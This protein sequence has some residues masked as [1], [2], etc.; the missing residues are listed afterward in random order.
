M[1]LWGPAF[2]G[3][4][5]HLLT[6]D[7]ARTEEAVS[8]IALWLR[9]FVSLDETVRAGLSPLSSGAFVSK[10]GPE[11]ADPEVLILPAWLADRCL[12]A[13][14]EET[15]LAVLG[16]VHPDVENRLRSATFTSAALLYRI[17]S[18]KHPFPQTDMGLLHQDMREGNFLPVNLAAGGLA[19]PLAL[20]IQRALAGAE[21]DPKP[22]LAALGDCRPA[23]LKGTESDEQRLA[24]EKE[25]DRFLKAKAPRVKARRFAARNAGLLLAALAVLAL[26]SFL[27]TSTLATR[28][29]GPD[30]VGMPPA[31]VL[32][33]YYN[34]FGELDHVLMDSILLRGIGRDDL[35]TV[36]HLFVINKVRM[37]HEFS[38]VPLVIS[39]DQ[40]LES[41]T[42]PQVT[43]FG[44]TD[45]R[46]LELESPPEPAPA[47]RK[48]APAE[49]ER[50]F[51]ADYLL[52]TQ[53]PDP[54][55]QD[56]RLPT[57]T[58]LPHSDIVTMVLR[59]GSWR[60]AGIERTVEAGE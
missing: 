8:A 4:S 2:D 3:E 60:I 40:W 16:Y 19:E 12:S 51:R 57:P 52:W 32:A 7:S 33:G 39:A 11:A 5:L 13:E 15:R 49:P 36:I 24:R 17:F 48:T 27:V 29:A 35:N 30:V 26:L 59:Q 28:P 56:D 31:E 55:E 18:G 45:L 1:I 43:V 41:G 38:Q 6:T 20:R 34:A 50:R 46:I 42:D 37:A 21:L 58:A 14:P 53:A 44:V 23:N 25:A 9:A 22:L 10:D 54:D 47:G